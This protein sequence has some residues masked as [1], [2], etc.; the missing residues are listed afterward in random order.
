VAAATLVATLS[1]GSPSKQM[2]VVGTSTMTL[3][4]GMVTMVVGLSSARGKTIMAFLATTKVLVVPIL[5]TA[6]VS[7][8]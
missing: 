1:V 4:A 3:A 6:L 2:V 8:T 5:V 7:R